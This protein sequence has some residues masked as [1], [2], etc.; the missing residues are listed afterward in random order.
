MLIVLVNWF[1]ALCAALKTDEKKP[2]APTGGLAAVKVPPGVFAS[3]MW[4]VKG[5]DVI[6]LESLL[7]VKVPVLFRLWLAALF[8]EV[9]LE[10][11]EVGADLAVPVPDA[12][13]VCGG[14]GNSEGWSMTGVGGVTKVLG[15]WSGFFGGSGW[16]VMIGGVGGIILGVTERP[17]LVLSSCRET[18]GRCS[19]DSASFLPIKLSLL[20]LP[21]NAAPFRLPP[22]LPAEL[23]ESVSAVLFFLLFMVKAPLKRSLGDLRR[24]CVGGEEISVGAVVTDVS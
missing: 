5:E 3:S 17:V 12:F 18:C 11:A 20:F 19:V 15:R 23:I 21:P 7:D 4:G 16:W 2:P 1:A 13:G 24:F 9:G 14:S 10:T 6:V 22:P 8:S